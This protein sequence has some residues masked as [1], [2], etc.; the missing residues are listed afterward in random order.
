MPIRNPA[1]PEHIP[2]Y[3][4]GADGSDPL[5]IFTLLLLLGGTLVIGTIYFRLHALPEQLGHHKL[6]WEICAVLALISLFTHEHIYWII[7][8]LLAVVDL[9]DFS[10]PLDRIATA[11]E[12]RP[13]T[14]RA[15][16][17]LESPSEEKPQAVSAKE[18][19]HA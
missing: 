3:I 4:P 18:T 2:F 14:L 17:A 5:M 13:S 9:P 1:A 8:L 15:P 16:P 19:S 10:G 7:A 11:L 12:R 6:Q